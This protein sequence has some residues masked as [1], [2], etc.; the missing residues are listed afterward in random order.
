MKQDTVDSRH[1]VLSGCSG[2]GKSTLL[3]ELGRRGFATVT[4]PGRR[5]VEEE[6]RGAGAAL[7][8]VDL[9]AFARRAINIAAHDRKRMAGATGWVFFDRGLVDALAALQYAEGQ[10][11]KDVL[12]HHQR[13]HRRVFLTPPWPE[14]YISDEG[15][16][17]DLT[18]AIAEYERLLEAYE[19]F[20]YQTIL[21]PKVDVGERA[22][23]VLSHLHH[24]CLP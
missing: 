21:I 24:S 11:A 22:D 23:F 1:I 4:E 3:A 9:S 20:G 7:P 2:G 12:S 17:H 8:W 14:I 6:L 15:R 10:P 18:D 19:E 5:I 13:Y 16:R